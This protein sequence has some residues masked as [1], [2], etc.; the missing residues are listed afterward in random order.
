MIQLFLSSG[1]GFSFG[2]RF[3]FAPSFTRKP[4]RS[5][6]IAERSHATPQS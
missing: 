2:T 6:R 4:L 5:V 1:A 3:V